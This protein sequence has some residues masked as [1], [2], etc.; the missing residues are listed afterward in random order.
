[1][2]DFG[3]SA[4]MMRVVSPLT[5]FSGGVA[6]LAFAVLAHDV[7]APEAVVSLPAQGGGVVAPVVAAPVAVMPDVGVYAAIAARP[8]FLPSRRAPAEAV[9]VAAAPV[10]PALDFSVVG[11]VT[12]AGQDMALVQRPGQAAAV[13]VRV[14]GLVD[15]WTVTAISRSGI[16]VRAGGT[17][18]ELKIV[19]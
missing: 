8:V 19:Q 10:V 11:V 16:F 6:V 12:G 9:G 3:V 2:H 13:L 14:G 18:A 15:G 17:S 1:V 4:D 5:W 7:M